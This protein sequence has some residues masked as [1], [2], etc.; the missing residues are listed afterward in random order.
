MVG[1]LDDPVGLLLTPLGVEIFHGWQFHPWCHTELCC[2]Q[3]VNCAPLEEC[4]G[5]HVEC[6]QL[7]EDEPLS[8][9]LSDG[10]G[11]AGPGQALLM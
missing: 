11:L 10:V 6:L 9:C 4:P 8:R 3:S 7:E 2:S 5:V 1:V